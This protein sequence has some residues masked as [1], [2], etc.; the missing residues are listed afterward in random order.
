MTLVKE[1]R[2]RLGRTP[3]DLA[4]IAGINLP[5]YYDLEDRQNEL[6]GAVAVA[7]VAKLAKELRVKPSAFFGGSSSETISV[8]D[9]ATRVREHL[10]RTGEA[11][12]AFEERIG[13]SVTEALADPDKFREC[14]A[15]ELRDICNGISINWFDVLD[16]LEDA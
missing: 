14:V 2:E 10:A 7:N 8:S 11:L 1:L 6:D 9:L 15:D 3:A 12:V 4:E 13:W 5:S 16:H